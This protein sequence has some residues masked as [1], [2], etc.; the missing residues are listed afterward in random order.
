MLNLTLALSGGGPVA[1]TMS[2]FGRWHCTVC[3]NLI[4]CDAS[5]N[6]DDTMPVPGRYLARRFRRGAGTYVATYVATVRDEII[7]TF[8]NLNA[9]ATQI[10]EAEF[11]RL[12]AQPAGDGCEEDLGSLAEAAQEKGEI[13]Y[14]TMDALR[15]TSL[16]LYAIG[17]FHL[18]EQQLCDLCRDASFGVKPPQDTK[19]EVLVSWYRK[20]FGV[21]LDAL[22]AWPAVNELRLL[23]NTAKHGAGSSAKQL[24][25]LRPD[26]FEDPQLR[27]LM[28]DMPELYTTA[29]VHLPLAGQD[30]FVSGET[31]AAYGAAAFEFIN[32]IAQ[33]FEGKAD[34]LFF[35]EAPHTP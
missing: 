14:N 33:H 27:D 29:H 13:F 9:R 34:D 28:P 15:R 26:L 3:A 6:A 2:H 32:E 20:H 22:S 5:I 30:L 8:S 1:K 16:T 23:A 25:E 17:L 21:D 18:L 10:A 19:L 24:R 4:H 31:F 12:G 35:V 7:P 11:A